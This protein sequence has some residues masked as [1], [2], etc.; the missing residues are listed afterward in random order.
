MP[1]DVSK[2]MRAVRS[3]GSEIERALGKAMWS[4]RLRYRKDN[5]H[6]FGNPDFTLRR[7]KIA[8]FADSEFWHGKDWSIR[9]HEHKSNIEFWHKKIESNI[10]RDRLVNETLKCAGWL[11]FRFWGREIKRNANG[12]AEKIST[13]AKA[14]GRGERDLS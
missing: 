7:L 8:V 9:K 11:V 10:R 5:R 12:C 14:L 6:I 3:S 2:N 4:V 13:I 1:R